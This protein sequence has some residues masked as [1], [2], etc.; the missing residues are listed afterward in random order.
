MMKDR[1]LILGIVG[2]IVKR[3][4]LLIAQLRPLFEAAS[5]LSTWTLQ[6]NEEDAVEEFPN[7]GLVSWKGVHP[8]L[9]VGTLWQFRIEDQDFK[10]DNPQH[11]AFCIAPGASAAREVLDLRRYGT[12]EDIRVLATE[13]GIPLRFVPSEAVFLWIEENT[14]VGPVHLRRAESGHWLLPGGPEGQ[15]LAPLPLNR[16]ASAQDVVSLNIQGPRQLLAPAGQPGPRIGSIDWSPDGTIVKRVLA[17][18]RKQDAH[19][20]E[21]L[22]LTQKSIDHAAEMVTAN[23]SVLQEQQIKRAAGIVHRMNQHVQ[24]TAE[25]MNELLGVPAVAR[26]IDEAKQEAIRLA[27]ASFQAKMAGERQH[28]DELQHQVAGSLQTLKGLEEQIANRQEEL[29]QQTNAV[30][31][32]T[33][34]RL[35]TILQKP[36]RFLA[37]IAIVKAALGLTEQNVHPVQRLGSS[38]STNGSSTLAYAPVTQFAKWELGSQVQDAKQLR[39]VLNT[40]F[41]DAGF[42]VSTARAVHSAF[43]CGRVPILYGADS[44]ELLKTYASRVAAARILWLPISPGLLEPSDLFGRTEPQSGHF[45]PRF[46][47][48][49]DL[50]V[51]ASTLEGLCMVVLD[52]VNR[53]AVDA[54]LAPVIACYIDSQ[55]G[56]TGRRLSIAHPAALGSDNP[57]ASLATLSWPQN[58]LLAGVLANDVTSLPPSPGFWLSSPLVCVDAKQGAE[59]YGSAKETTRAEKS[60]SRTWI[61]LSQWKEYGRLIIDKDTSGLAKLWPEMEDKKVRIPIA[62]REACRSF[63]AAAVAW[64]TEPKMALEETLDNCLV[65]YFVAKGKDD[66]LLD[67]ASRGNSDRKALEERIAL[68]KEALR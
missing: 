15:A 48:L 39:L 33:Q 60:S 12:A 45:A 28:L 2:K 18:V 55:R 13:I 52:G 37:D 22:Q 9:E 5:D 63:Y 62:L 25:F 34:A 68:V 30:S 42:S 64:P 11:D 54:Y 67:V 17:R 1:R 26:K 21:T 56:V 10:L 36:A 31:D 7:R 16:A 59:I 29:L 47:G 46:G 32:E 44:Y 58:V 53:S 3:D 8:S 14:W 20:A 61:G 24:V 57:Y 66:A 27:E 40:S 50:M 23:E 35:Q 38:P 41:R 43:V 4:R 6:Y 51:E 65:P 19:I 49:L